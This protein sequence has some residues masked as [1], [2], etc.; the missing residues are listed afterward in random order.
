MPFFAPDVR[1]LE[2]ALLIGE[3]DCVELIK[4]IVPGLKGLPTSMWRQ[5]PR[6]LDTTTLLPGTAIATFVDGR[7]PRNDSGQHAALFIAYAGQSIWV[8]DQWKN[9]PRKPKVS[10]RL[11]RPGPPRGQGSLSNDSRAF[12]VIELR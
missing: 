2:G 3:G 12:Y 6:V 9:D 11:I 7:Y 8:M 4:A 5:G 10:K 1:Q